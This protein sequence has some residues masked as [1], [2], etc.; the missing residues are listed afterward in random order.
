MIPRVEDALIAE[1]ERRVAESVPESAPAPEARPETFVVAI[2]ERRFEKCRQEESAV[3]IYGRV[4]AAVSVCFYSQK[5]RY[6]Y[7]AMMA[8]FSGNPHLQIGGGLPAEIVEINSATVEEGPYLTSD[9]WTFT[10]RYYIWDDGE[11]K[12]WRRPA[13]N[14]EETAEPCVFPQPRPYDPNSPEAVID[15]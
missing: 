1:L 2:E 8:S 6:D 7:S 4:E 11:G 9:A 12:E 13:I 14:S 3:T 10:V 15:V 5:T